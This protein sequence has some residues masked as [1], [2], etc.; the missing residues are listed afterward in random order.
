MLVGFSLNKFSTFMINLV[1]RFAIESNSA[2]S[3]G[4]RKRK[5]AFLTEIKESI[6]L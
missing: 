4:K 6:K 2:L 1:A 3:L 5:A